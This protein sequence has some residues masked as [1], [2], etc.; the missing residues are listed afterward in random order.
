MFESCLL[1]FIEYLVLFLSH[2]GWLVSGLNLRTVFFQID[3][4]R[5]VKL[6]CLRLSYYMDKETGE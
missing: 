1:M 5:Y 2:V 4:W 3:M 6:I